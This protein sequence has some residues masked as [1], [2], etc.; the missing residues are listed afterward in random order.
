MAGEVGTR[1]AGWSAQ[2]FW[3]EGAR[4]LGYS[5]YPGWHSEGAEALRQA[6]AAVCAAV[7]SPGREEHLGVWGCIAFLST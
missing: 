3:E 4:A 6:C 2:S 5:E 1:A 7:R